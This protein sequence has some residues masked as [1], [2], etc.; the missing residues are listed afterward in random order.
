M[1]NH[2]TYD[3]YECKYCNHLPFRTAKNLKLHIRNSAKC[4]EKDRTRA[5]P[6]ARKHHL[7]DPEIDDRSDD[8]PTEPNN[9]AEDDNSFEPN[10]IYDEL[11]TR[12]EAAIDAL[13]GSAAEPSREPLPGIASNADSST[14]VQEKSHW[15]EDFPRP[16]GETYGKGKTRFDEILEYESSMDWGEY[17]PFE[18]KSEWELAKFLFKNMNKSKTDEFLKLDAIQDDVQPSFNNSRELLGKIDDLPKGPEWFCESITIEGDVS[19][20]NGK[21]VSEEVELWGRDILEGIAE[22]FGKPSIEGMLHKPERHYT[23]SDGTEQIISQSNTASAWWD[24]QEDLPDGATVVPLIIGSD[25]TQLSVFSGD[26][27]AWPVYLTIGNIPKADRRCP[28]K[29]TQFLLGYLPVTKLKI[30]SNKNTRRVQIYRL[31]HRCMRRLLGPLYNLKEKELVEMV[32]SDSM[33]RR[34]FIFLLAYVADHPE[35]CLVSCNAESMCPTCDR[36]AKER[37]NPVAGKTKD[38]ADLVNILR[39]HGN[40]LEPQEFDD[41]NLRSIPEPFWAGLQNCDISMAFAPDLLHQ[42]YKGVFK[43]H[44]VSWCT[45]AISAD[46]NVAEREV[47][48]RF[49]AT[50]SHSEL[51][52]FKDGISGI[53]QWT[54]A[55]FKEM[56]KIFYAI[57][58]D[59]VDERV[60]IAAKALLD[61][62][63]YA[64]LQVQTTTTLRAMDV[65]LGRFHK[66]KDVFVEKGIRDHFNIPKVHAL[67]HYVAKIKRLG[68]ND[69]FNTEAT[70]RLHIGMAKEAYRASNRRD[71]HAQMTRHLSRLESLELFGEYLAWKKERRVKDVEANT[72][73]TQD[74]TSILGK[75]ARQAGDSSADPQL[76]NNAPPAKRYK[77]SKRPRTGDR[78]VPLAILKERHQV[79]EFTPALTK[80]L[81]AEGNGDTHLFNESARFDTFTRFSVT[82]PKLYHMPEED[83]DKRKDRIR[84]RPATARS[85]RKKAKPAAF[86]TVLAR[87][88][89]NH[90]VGSVEESL[91]LKGLRAAQVRLIFKL[92]E[93]FKCSEHLAYVE[94][95]NPFRDPQPNGLYQLSRSM[96]RGSKRNAEIIPLRNIVSSCHLV[97]RFGKLKCHILY[98]ND[99]IVM[100]PLGGRLH[101]T[102]AS[103]E[104]VEK[105]CEP[106]A[107]SA[108]AAAACGYHIKPSASDKGFGI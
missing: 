67:V 61:F 103:A 35:Q 97:P 107:P 69:G 85:G 65:A 104:Q 71:Y 72:H 46:S 23:D 76:A 11:F 90:A 38:T 92:P 2:I 44:L 96:Q 105:K 108:F 22:L 89:N 52:S 8:E 59:A 16:A 53:S 51:K 60:A 98:Y 70:E 36:R 29:R 33:I 3:S 39:D 74:T 87:C 93:E 6:V 18:S 79:H 102:F 62:L 66:Y 78:A 4:A 41:L 37:E 45:E 106:C 48:S 99:G 80:F 84:A 42:M 57:I 50:P 95:M 56:A 9:E 13:P 86:D 21:P 28:S 32:G 54:G 68:T 81:N 40:N 31:F 34:C 47:D 88:N 1:S 15:V 12:F 17:G 94:W 25:K 43:E 27:S 58:V 83:D 49:I 55:E 5:Q 26:K 63:E 24:A 100:F 75:R 73:A 91:D 64:R 19:D 30:F 10:P 77:I 101:T 82:L 14:S 20:A 7:D